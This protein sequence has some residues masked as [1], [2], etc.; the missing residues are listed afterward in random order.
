[1]IEVRELCKSYG[2]RQAIFNLSFKIEKG[3]VVGGRFNPQVPDVQHVSH[4]VRLSDWWC[5][6]AP[7]P[8]PG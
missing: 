3:D 8:P 5:A 6:T 1:M 4:R 7:N 2:E